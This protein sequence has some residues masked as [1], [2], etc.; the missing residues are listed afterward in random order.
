MPNKDT[1]A[2]TPEMPAPEAPLTDADAAPAAS[3]PGAIARYLKQLPASPGVYRMLD[4]E[5]NVIYVGKARNLKARV[6]NYARARRPHQPHRPHDR[7]RPRPWS[8]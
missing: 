6:T 4:A 5:G 7:Q 8:S 2:P 3:G 1:S